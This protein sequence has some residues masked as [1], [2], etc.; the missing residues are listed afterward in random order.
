MSTGNVKAYLDLGAKFGPTCVAFAPNEWLNDTM[1]F[2]G[3]HGSFAYRQCWSE[4]SSHQLDNLVDGNTI[5]TA[6]RDVGVVIAGGDCP[7]RRNSYT[8]P[9]FQALG[10]E[11]NSRWI[12][13]GYPSAAT[14]AGW[15][16]AALGSF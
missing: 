10:F 4:G 13:T 7:G 11:P 5:Y 2:L 12:S 8:L 1:V 16:R 14:I 9:E 6:S 15:A 3:T